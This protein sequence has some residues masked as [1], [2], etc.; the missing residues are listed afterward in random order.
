MK[1]DVLFERVKPKPVYKHSFAFSHIERSWRHT[2]AKSQSVGR[3]SSLGGCVFHYFC[4]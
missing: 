2:V 1:P 4:P 3:E